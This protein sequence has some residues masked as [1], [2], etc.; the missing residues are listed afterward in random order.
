MRARILTGAINYAAHLAIPTALDFHQAISP[1]AKLRHLQ[2]LRD[3]WVNGIRDV[4]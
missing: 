3:H 1:E 4:H 2:R